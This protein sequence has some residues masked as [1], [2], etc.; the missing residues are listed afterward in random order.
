MPFREDSLK[1]SVHEYLESSSSSIS[2]LLLGGGEPVTYPDPLPYST[3]DDSDDA[4]LLHTLGDDDDYAVPPADVTREIH[5]LVPAP[6]GISAIVRTTGRVSQTEGRAHEDY[7]D[8]SVLPVVYFAFVVFHPREKACVIPM[9]LSD[10]NGAVL[11]ADPNDTSNT[12]VVEG[13]LLTEDSGHYVDVN[14]HHI[15]T[16][17]TLPEPLKSRL[18]PTKKPPTA[19]GLGIV[20]L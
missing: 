3:C 10:A 8:V 5:K 12:N 7:D 16:M 17:D 19:M 18:I 15:F 20:P 13:Y 6:R 14:V 2:A 4:P 9:V 11:A 1:G